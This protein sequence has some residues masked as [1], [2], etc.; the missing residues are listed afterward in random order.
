MGEMEDLA[1]VML[2]MAV[3]IAAGFTLYSYLSPRIQKPGTPP[4]Q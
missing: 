3:G 2:W 1:L 4:T